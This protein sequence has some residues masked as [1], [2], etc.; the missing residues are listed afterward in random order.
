MT[1]LKK[2]EVSS[3]VQGP[4]FVPAMDLYAANENV[5]KRSYRL[6]NIDIV[7]GLVVLIMALDHVRDYMMVG[8]VQDPIAQPDISLGLYITRW[9]TNFC[10]PVFIF[11]A[12]TSV[13]LMT[14]RRSKNEISAFVFKRGLW[15]ILMEITIVAT[16]WTFTPLGEA[17]IGGLTIVPLQVIWALGASMIFLAGAQFFGPKVCLV[18]GAAIISYHNLLDGIWPVATL[19]GEGTDAFWTTLH[20][21][22]TVIFGQFYINTVYPLLPCVGIM[23]LG[24][25]SSSIFK[26]APKERNT[27]LLKIGL[28]FVAAFF[29]IRFPGGYGDPNPWQVQDYG[30]QATIFDFMNVSKYPASFLYILSTLGVMSIVCSF[31]DKLKG[32]IKNVLVM[33]GRVPFAFYIAHL[34]LI[35][36]LSVGLGMLQGFEFNQMMHFFPL[37]PKGYG[38]G[39]LEVYLIWGLVIAILYPF[40]KWVAEIKRT[41]KD[42]WLSYL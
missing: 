14:D 24:Y 25:G 5:D 42:W 10:A 30:L 19:F 13:G 8:G 34:Y 2:R 21:Q 40:C 16:A 1:A 11:L 41:R 23:L 15:L 3:E 27:L 38:V 26:K 32:P 28:I 36:A 17:A 31:A 39:L 18:L 12:G 29:A 22:N 33:F 7:R 20:S 37:Y 4:V 6:T 9:I 35:H